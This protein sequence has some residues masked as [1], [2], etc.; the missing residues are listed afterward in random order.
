[1][2]DPRPRLIHATPTATLEAPAATRSAPPSPDRAIAIEIPDEED[3][4][5]PDPARIRRIL[6]RADAD[7]AVLETDVYD[8]I[9]ALGLPTPRRILLSLD[10]IANLSKPPD[11]PGPRVFLKLQAPGVLHKT[12]AGAVR[13]VPNDVGSIRATTLE[14][15]RQC[16]VPRDRIRGV[17]LV[18][19]VLSDQSIGR[20]E[21]LLG[22]RLTFDFGPVVTLG[23]GGIAAEFW[24]GIAGDALGPVIGSARDFDIGKAEHLLDAVPISPLWRGYRGSERLVD[25]RELARWLHK[26]AALI[27]YF[28]GTT[29]E[30]SPRIVEAEINPL[31]VR[32]NRVVPLDGLIRVDAGPQT[33]PP[34]LDEPT[35]AARLDRLLRPRTIAV[36]GVSTKRQNPGRII[37]ENLLHEGWSA[38]RL[39]VVKPNAWPADRIQGIPCY[40]TL[41]DVP[42]E[43]DLYVLAVEAEET[44]RMLEGSGGRAASALLIAGGTSER[45]AG[46]QLAETIGAAL[47]RQ[48]MTAIG[49]NS[50]GVISRP[51]KV[52]T[53]FL[54][55][56]KLP[57]SRG[58]SGPLAY[59]S[60]S[61]AF[62][63]TRMSRMPDFEPRYEVSTGNQLRVSVVD[64]V[65][66]LAEDPNV[67]VFATYVE[68]FGRHEG[69]RFRDLARRLSREGRKVIVYK[70]GRTKRG[71]GAAGGHTASIVGDHRVGRQLLADSGVLR[72]DTFE[73]FEDLI[74]LAVGWIDRPISAARLAA[75]S[76][77]GYECVGIADA[78]EAPL[79][80]VEFSDETQASLCSALAARQIDQLVDIR[81]PLDLTPMA[82]AETWEH[83]V[84]ILLEDDG[85]DAL[86]VSPVPPTPAFHSLPRG[87]GHREDLDAPG[88]LAHRLRETIGRSAKPVGLVV[89]CGRQYDPFADALGR[90]GLPVFRSAD[91]AVRAM[92]RYV[93]SCKAIG[94]MDDCTG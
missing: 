92:Q 58:G 45:A 84:R 56:E 87:E 14:M 25:D 24:S 18:E 73:Q 6:E 62:M 5:V 10:R 35:K 40:P 28:D 37:L 31:V 94:L 29:R 2:S 22:A 7:G 33:P 4:V 46:E 23:Q 61:G 1:M 82:D 30:R 53:L 21:L 63:I 47:D 80:P 44:L 76:N 78:I 49:P 17:L 83:V 20:L 66:R 60:Q 71:A 55:K 11:L 64:V 81:N 90:D 15:L 42:F 54:P 9:D 74:R 65:E 19:E 89:D 3:A 16:G 48:R 72:A 93:E 26:W 8:A 77:A 85:I 67:R 79:E 52:D 69:L 12:E 70:A 34:V 32:D 36:A 91:R 38:D 41:A 51:A 59:I 43:V 39:A 75:V 13:R 27:N 88:Q 86:V 68:G 57:R 50:L